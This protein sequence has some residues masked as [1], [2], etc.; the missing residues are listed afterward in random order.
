MIV[1]R[2]Q[3]VSTRCLF[4]HGCPWTPWEPQPCECSLSSTHSSIL[5][6]RGLIR[7]WKVEAIHSS[8]ICEVRPCSSK[9]WWRRISLLVSGCLPDPKQDAAPLEGFPPVASH[10]L[11][12]IFRRKSWA[13][14]GISAKFQRAAS[15]P[16]KQMFPP[17]CFHIL[18]P[19]LFLPGVI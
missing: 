11:G 17:H 10:A 8:L 7:S 3:T 15:R 13:V 18:S 1:L 6:I 12:S 4:S 16:W 9:H 19:V 14:R 2:T 5:L